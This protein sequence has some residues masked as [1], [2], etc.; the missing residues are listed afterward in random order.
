MEAAM[1]KLGLD[2]GE[3]HERTTTLLQR[4]LRDGGWGLTA[5]VRTSPAAYLGSLAACYTEPT[6]APYRDTTPLPSSSLLHGWV[7]DGLRRVRQAALGGKYQNDI[8]PLL[9]ITASSFFT[10]YSTATPSV[11]ATLQRSLNAKANQHTIEAAV[12]QMKE[13]SRRGDKWEIAHHKAVTA[14]G[15]WGWKVVVPESPQMRLSDVEYAVAARLSLDLHPFPP[16]A[17]EQLPA[18]CPLC[19]HRHTGAPVP[20]RSDSWYRPSGMDGGGSGTEGSERA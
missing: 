13:T 3:R 18:Y 14:K 11:T 1:N 20:V 4:K 6:F 7:E 19:S 10:H 9:P 15:A 5:A 8:E 17:V 12:Q 2:E 16:R